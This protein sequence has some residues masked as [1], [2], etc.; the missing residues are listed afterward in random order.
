MLNQ[1]EKQSAAEDDH[2]PDNNSVL[3][4]IDVFRF[5]CKVLIDTKTSIQHANQEFQ[6][7]DSEVGEGWLE[8]PDHYKVE[9]EYHTQSTVTSHHVEGFAFEG[10]TQ[11]SS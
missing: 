11:Q 6:E 3:Q 1:T 5:L 7:D 10:H 9:E 4:P 2:H 8:W